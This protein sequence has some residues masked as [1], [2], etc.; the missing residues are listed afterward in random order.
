[1]RVILILDYFNQRRGLLFNAKCYACIMVHGARGRTRTCD[2]PVISR[3]LQPTKLPAQRQVGDRPSHHKDDG[4]LI[5]LS[6][7]GR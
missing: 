7:L 2:L 4:M 5:P 1:M 3:V 6:H